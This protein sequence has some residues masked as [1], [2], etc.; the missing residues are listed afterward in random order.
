MWQRTGEDGP[1]DSACGPGSGPQVEIFWRPGC[2]YCS[3]LRR[4]LT[5]RQVPATWRNIWDDPAARDV[6][7]SANSG[8]ETVPTVRVGSQT[9]TNPSWRQ[10]APLLG[11]GQWQ[12]VPS[13]TNH[14]RRTVMS[15]S[16]V[17]LFA[18]ISLVLTF[19][20]H[21][22]VAWAADALTVASW[23]VTRRLRT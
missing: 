2:P 18:I 7:R 20:G 22:G 15:W 3:R 6:V 19:T 9:L 16:P 17:V 4:D 8:N 13:S 23:W 21:D 14:R 11:N 1:A 10:L 5:R 12:Q